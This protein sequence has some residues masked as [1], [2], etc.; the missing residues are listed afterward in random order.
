MSSGVQSKKDTVKSKS[1]AEIFELWILFNTTFFSIS[2]AREIE[3][4]KFRLTHE[5]AILIYTLIKNG[6]SATLSEIAESTIRQYHS[7][8]TLVKRMTKSGLV[9]KIKHSDKKKFEV[10]I[11][12]KGLEI[13]NKIPR[14]SIEMTFSV[15]SPRDQNV[16]AKHLQR[17]TL[18]ARN[19][20]NLDYKHPFLP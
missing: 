19:L 6:G 5:Q 8:S 7:V 13:Y 17:L 2:R 11:T 16:L 15:L 20:L 12:D 9:K 18:R 10:S 14:K 4:A 3:I 1:P